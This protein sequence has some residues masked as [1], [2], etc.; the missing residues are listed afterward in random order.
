MHTHRRHFEQPIISWAVAGA[1]LGAVTVFATIA[2]LIVL[3]KSDGALFAVAGLAAVFGGAGF[4]AM[5]GA[6]L[7][8]LR[9]TAVKIVSVR[10]PDAEGR[11]QTSSS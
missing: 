4:G 1:A 7:A 10:G 2:V 11:H 9:P 3:T 8:S 5:M 6:V